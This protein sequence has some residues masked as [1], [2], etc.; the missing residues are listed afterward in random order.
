MSIHSCSGIPARLVRQLRLVEVRAELAVRVIERV[1]GEAFGHAR[2]IVVGG[3]ESRR[4]LH[5]VEADQERRAD[6]REEPRT[7]IRIEVP[8]RA[9]E[10]GDQAVGQRVEVAL[11][12][13]NQWLDREAG[14]VAASAAALARSASSLTS[15]GTKRSSVSESAS[16]RSRVFP[17]LPEPSSISVRAPV[18]AMSAECVAEDLR[19]AARQVV[20]GQPRHLLVQPRPCAR[21]RAR[22]RRAPSARSADPHASRAQRI[23]EKICRRCGK[24]Q[25]RKLG[26]ATSGSVAQ[27]PPRRTRYSVPKNASEYSR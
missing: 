24:S 14:I 9:A 8:D 11:E 16:S 26:R 19:L 3:L 2:G 6:L 18:S 21:R 7:L 27:E 10:E 23:P 15:S 1:A 13:R 20:L 22:P 12:V 25:L 17:V 5:E 4:V